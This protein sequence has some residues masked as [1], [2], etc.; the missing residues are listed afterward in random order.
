MAESLLV[1]AVAE[2]PRYLVAGGVVSTIEVYDVRGLVCV[3]DG[4]PVPG[5]RLLDVW[6]V[7]SRSRPEAVAG[8]VYSREGARSPRVVEVETQYVIR[9]EV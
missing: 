6:A 2:D 9:G 7:T 4:I 5:G 3:A 8:V 1:E